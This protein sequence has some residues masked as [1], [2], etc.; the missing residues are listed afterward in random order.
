ML[1]TQVRSSGCSLGTSDSAWLVSLWAHK[2]CWGWTAV[3]VVMDRKLKVRSYPC[4]AFY[5]AVWPLF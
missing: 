3:F 2:D 4:L 5:T 1:A